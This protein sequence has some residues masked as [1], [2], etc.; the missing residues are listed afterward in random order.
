MMF[1]PAQHAVSFT[2]QCLALLYGV[3]FSEYFPDDFLHR[4]V[5]AVGCRLYGV[6][7][8]GE[9]GVGDVFEVER[10][11]ALFLHHE[12]GEEAGGASV[13]FAEWVDEE[14]FGMD[15]RDV[16]DEKVRVGVCVGEFV[17]EVAFE[18]AHGLVDVYG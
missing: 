15:A 8:F 17:E 16:A 3:F 5:V 9:V 6:D 12:V 2:L 13:A 14:Q 10:G 18:L 1:L 11:I 4:A 7:V